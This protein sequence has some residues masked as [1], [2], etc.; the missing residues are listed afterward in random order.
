MST[1]YLPNVH[2]GM[3]LQNCPKMN[4][5]QN[6]KHPNHAKSKLYKNQ[7][8]HFD[9]LYNFDFCIILILYNFDLG[10]F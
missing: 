2:A 9:Y 5:V 7:N 6:Q 3:H 10:R 4:I 8:A 1:L